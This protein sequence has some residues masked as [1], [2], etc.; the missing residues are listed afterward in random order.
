MSLHLLL[1]SNLQL[2][3]LQR[4]ETWATC[5]M[6]GMYCTEYKYLD[7][8]SVCLSVCPKLDLFLNNTQQDASSVSRLIPRMAGYSLFPQVSFSSHVF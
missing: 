5:N 7:L 2:L 1:Y 8:E 6:N 4:R 3:T